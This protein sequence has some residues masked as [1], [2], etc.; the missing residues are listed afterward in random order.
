MIAFCDRELD[1][2]GDISGR[3][4]LYAGGTSPLWIE[5]LAQRIGAAGSL[6]AV[7]LDAEGLRA[8]KTAFSPNDLPMEPDYVAVDVFDLPFA[9]DTF[10]LV[11]SS[12]L[13]HELDASKREGGV[14]DALRGMEAV[15]RPGG[16]VVAGDFVDD[17]PSSQVEEERIF[18]EVSHLTTGAG[19]FGIGSRG[20]IERLLESAFVSYGTEGHPPFGIRHLDTLFL[21]QPVPERLDSLKRADAGRLRLRWQK[22]R[23]RVE[24]DGYTRPAT[25]RITV[26]A[27]P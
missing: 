10:D 23:E 16:V 15:V 4:V 19:M 27:G 1:L 9:R 17:L 25:V 12:G 8:A 11:Y 20:R 5:G 3:N 24:Q 6:I 2:L 18:A 14:L 21:A 22:L 26:P 13:L 7:D